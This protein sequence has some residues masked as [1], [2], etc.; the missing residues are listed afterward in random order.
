MKPIRFHERA[1]AEIKEILSDD[2]GHSVSESIFYRDFDFVTLNMQEN[3]RIYQRIQAIEKFEYRRAKFKTLPF[4]LVYR[5]DEDGLLVTSIYH[6]SRDPN[7][8]HD[9]VR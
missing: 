3:P 9:R 5:V 6:T 4:V 7:H 2:D 1:R 8:W